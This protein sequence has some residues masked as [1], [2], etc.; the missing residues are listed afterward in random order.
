[1]QQLTKLGTIVLRKLHQK[2]QRTI[3][4]ITKTIFG[5]KCCITLEPIAELHIS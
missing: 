2:N 1:M 5:Q 4:R 3:S